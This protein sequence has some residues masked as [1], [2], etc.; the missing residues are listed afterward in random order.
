MCI[1]T[2]KWNF[3]KCLFVCLLRVCLSEY[4]G[5]YVSLN[6][7]YICMPYVCKHINSCI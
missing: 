5:V 2:D 4:I 1:E 3:F 6:N 7:V